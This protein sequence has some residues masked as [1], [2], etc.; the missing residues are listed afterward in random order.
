MKEILASRFDFTLNENKYILKIEVE[1]KGEVIYYTRGIQGRVVSSTAITFIYPEP[2]PV[3][4][5]PDVDVNDL[6]G[7]LD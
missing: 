2:K 3:K 1:D 4:E 5:E 7:L 6:T